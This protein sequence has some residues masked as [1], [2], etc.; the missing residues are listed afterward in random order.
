MT[1][2]IKRQA[3]YA[4]ILAKNRL[5]DAS[6]HLTESSLEGVDMISDAMMAL[7]N[8]KLYLSDGSSTSDDSEWSS[9]DS[10]TVCSTISEELSDEASSTS[11]AS[12]DSDGYHETNCDGADIISSMSEESFG[13][14]I[15]ALSTSKDYDSHKIHCDEDE[16]LSS[17]LSYETSSASWVSRDYNG[18]E[19]TCDEAEI[20]G[21]VLDDTKSI[22]P[23]SWVKMSSKLSDKIPRSKFDLGQNQHLSTDSTDSTKISG[24]DKEEST[25]DKSS[26]YSL[27]VIRN[28]NGC[29]EHESKAL[30]NVRSWTE[31]LTKTW[32]N[33]MTFHTNIPRDNHLYFNKRQADSILAESIMSG[34]SKRRK[35][36]PFPLCHIPVKTTKFAVTILLPKYQVQPLE[37]NTSNNAYQTEGAFGIIADNDDISRVVL[38]ENDAIETILGDFSGTMTI[39]PAGGIYQHISNNAKRQLTLNGNVVN[40]SMPEDLVALQSRKDGEINLINTTME[41]NATDSKFKS[42]DKASSHKTIANPDATKPLKQKQGKQEKAD[43]LQNNEQE[44]F[45]RRLISAVPTSLL[46][47]AG[48]S[49]NLLKSTREEK[50]SEKKPESLSTESKNPTIEQGL[51]E[52]A[53]SNFNKTLTNFSNRKIRLGRLQ[54]EEESRMD[55]LCRQQDEILASGNSSERLDIFKN[56]IKSSEFDL[57]AADLSH[58]QETC[59]NHLK[60]QKLTNQVELLFTE[61]IQSQPPR[62]EIYVARERISLPY[63]DMPEARFAAKAINENDSVPVSMNFRCNEEKN[64]YSLETEEQEDRYTPKRDKYVTEDEMHTQSNEKGG[65]YYQYPSEDFHQEFFLEPITEQLSYEHV[66]GIKIDRE[67]F[68]ETQETTKKD[69]LQTPPEEIPK[70]EINVYLTPRTV[71]GKDCIIEEELVREDLRSLINP[72]KEISKEFA[73]ETP[74][75]HQSQGE[76]L[77]TDRD[78]EELSV[79]VVDKDCMRPENEEQELF[80]KDLSSLIDPRNDNNLELASE[81]T[82]PS[83]PAAENWLQEEGVGND[84]ENEIFNKT[85]DGKDCMRRENEQQEHARKDIGS[86]IEPRKEKN[87]EFA[88]ESIVQNRSREESVGSDLENEKPNSIGEGANNYIPPSASLKVSQVTDTNEEFHPCLEEQMSLNLATSEELINLWV[89]Q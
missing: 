23:L 81:R 67:M 15:N 1:S 29:E 20:L 68:D 89:R 11:S 35:L 8:G 66:E 86:L 87:Q 79:A 75:E 21:P 64:H 24:S 5:D 36:E 18:R 38:L 84:Q 59:Y 55:N 54:I 48:D 3:N 9:F 73:L 57:I 40:K 10:N 74:A 4:A 19:H 46:R 44:Y 58:E 16:I 12:S 71:D 76:R 60:T 53:L 37:N 50:Q 78:N 47:K 14:K 2:A 39:V 65:D 26:M 31:V 6:M 52:S 30:L 83:S 85:V 22:G 88:P 77:G 28:S 34:V 41:L 25:S 56:K 43:C 17:E 7:W 33:L 49:P 62:R 70:G 72:A 82:T 13:E 27:T 32:F 45:L 51:L 80:R 42:N 63:Q 61:S 69:I